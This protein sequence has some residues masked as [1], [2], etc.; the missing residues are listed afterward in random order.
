MHAPL[1][2]VVHYVRPSYEG[3]FSQAQPSAAVMYS[4]TGR[5][6]DPLPSQYYTSDEADVLYHP[7]VVPLDEFLRPGQPVALTPE[8]LARQRA[9][10]EARATPPVPPQGAPPAAAPEEDPFADDSDKPAAPAAAEV[11]TPAEMPEVEAAPEAEAPPAS[12]PADS[13][14]DP[15][16]L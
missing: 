11:A 15:F 6:A 1:L 2:P 4:S 12:A 10:A 14:E 9:A 16:N 13:D 3:Y 5:A 8:Q 7:V